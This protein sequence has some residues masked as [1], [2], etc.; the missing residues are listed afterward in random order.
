MGSCTHPGTGDDLFMVTANE[1]V[2]KEEFSK[3][4]GNRKATRRYWSRFG[5][6]GFIFKN[7]SDR[8][9]FVEAMEPS[10]KLSISEDEARSYLRTMNAG[11]NDIVN[12]V[13]DS[14]KAGEAGPFIQS[15]ID[16][17]K[18]NIIGRTPRSLIERVGSSANSIGG[19]ATDDGT[20]NII[21]GNINKPGNK[22]YV[23]SILLH[24]AFHAAAPQILGEKEMVFFRRG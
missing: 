19:F 9:K 15:L 20:V 23:T 11:S 14:L 10:E 13:T 7:N 2:S 12:K 8:V 5:K 18:L 1:R 6:A 22:D 4:E 3:N 21:A 16:N 17:G 24:E